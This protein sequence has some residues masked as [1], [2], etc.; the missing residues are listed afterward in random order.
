LSEGEYDLYGYCSA[1]KTRIL[2]ILSQKQNLE[3]YNE[4]TLKQVMHF[5]NS[6]P[7]K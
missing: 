5:W 7:L 4:H 6:W 1:T 2:V 3:M